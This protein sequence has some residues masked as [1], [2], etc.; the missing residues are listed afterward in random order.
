MIR[1]S[2]TLLSKRASSGRTIVRDP[3]KKARALQIR[4]NEQEHQ[5]D[6]QQRP[7]RHP[8]AFEP[9]QNNQQA[10]G[11]TMA[12]Y[13]LAGAGMAVGFALVGALFGG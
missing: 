5:I 12:S 2:V 4:D 10:V 11:S 8:L 7:L 6:Q 9:T 13:A 1:R 3:R